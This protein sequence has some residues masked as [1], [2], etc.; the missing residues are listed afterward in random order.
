MRKRKRKASVWHTSGP[1]RRTLWPQWETAIICAFLLRKKRFGQ[2][3]KQLTVIRENRL[4]VSCQQSLGIKWAL[5][6]LGTT[7]IHGHLWIL[8]YSAI[9]ALKTSHPTRIY[10]LSLCTVIYMP[11]M[12]GG[13]KHELRFSLPGGEALVLAM[14]SKEQAEKWLQVNT[15]PHSLA[16]LYINLLYIHTIDASCC[17]KQYCTRGKLLL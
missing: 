5:I 13:E 9:K 11:K 8:F 6:F 10:P 3:A 15:V 16:C 2:W 12:A 14:Q 1:Q 7:M 4:Q 17:Q